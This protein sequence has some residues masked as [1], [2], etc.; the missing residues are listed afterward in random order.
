M[1][2]MESMMKSVGTAN[3]KAVNAL[4][5]IGR[6][7]RYGVHHSLED[8]TKVGADFFKSNGFLKK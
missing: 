5:R 1:M 6:Y 8:A 2:M 3:C 7:V 4:N